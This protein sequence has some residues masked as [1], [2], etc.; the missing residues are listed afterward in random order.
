MYVNFSKE[1]KQQ[2]QKTLYNQLESLPETWTEVS[3]MLGYAYPSALTEWHKH[4]K[5][6]I[7]RVVQV[8]L[9]LEQYN[10]ER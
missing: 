8:H 3:N 5:V 2:M 1:Q 4:R 6:P 10:K 9:F 7:A